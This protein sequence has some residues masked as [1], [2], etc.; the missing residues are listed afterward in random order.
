MVE[1][2]IRELEAILR[3]AVA[4]TK[5][6]DTAKVTLGST[7]TLHDFS[8]GEE[9]RYT[10]VHPRE[11]SPAKGKLSIASPTGKALL[12]RGWGEVI[13]VAAPAG[14]LRYRIERIEG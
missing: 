10:L 14:T 5:E 12:G 1:A 6:V 13:D 4:T 3:S 8:C 9:L 2:R 11:A 7:V